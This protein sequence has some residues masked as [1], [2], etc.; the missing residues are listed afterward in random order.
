MRR[1]LGA[2]A[3]RLLA[4]SAGRRAR[5]VPSCSAHVVAGGDEVA[6]QQLT[7][8]WMTRRSPAASASSAVSRRPHGRSDPGPSVAWIPGCRPTARFGRTVPPGVRLRCRTAAQRPA[9]RHGP[10]STID[11]L[12]VDAA[13]EAGSVLLRRIEGNGA[14]GAHV[15]ASGMLGEGG[16]LS[17]GMLSLVTRGCD[18]TGRAVADS[19][20]ARHRHS[21]TGLPNW[22]CRSRD[23]RRRWLSDVR[24]ALADGRLEA[25]ADDRPAVGRMERDA[26]IAPSRRAPA[27]R[28]AR[29]AGATRS[30][31]LPAWLGDG[32]LSL[33]A[34]L[35]ARART[36]RRGEVR[37]HRG[38]AACQRQSRSGPERR[39]TAS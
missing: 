22:M 11:G 38:G 13:I 29:P 12:A 35:A 23:R 17:D 6:L 27:D 37:P 18:A 31:G 30:A 3:G 32:S 8:S 25:S 5:S 4:Q 26:R 34:H 28:D 7:G 1:C 21:G 24:L 10:V 33:V 19:P 14:K 36:A 39:R 15:V 9:R 20:G 16:R 2:A